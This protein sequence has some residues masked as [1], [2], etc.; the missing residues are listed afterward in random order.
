MS[1]RRRQKARRQP[2]AWWTAPWLAGLFLVVLAVYLG[3][4]LSAPC[5]PW[6]DW[7]DGG[8]FVS[9]LA[10]TNPGGPVGAVLSWSLNVLFGAVWVWTVPVL[11]LVI[12][13]ATLLQR[14]SFLGPL[15]LR[16]GPIWLV[17]TAWLGQP[18][19]PW[20][21]AES[22]RLAG[23]A[24]SWLG[25]AMHGLVGPW[26]SQLFLGLAVAVVLILVARPVLRPAFGWL[27]PV[28]RGL[29][30]ALAA[31]AGWGA[32]QLAAIWGRLRAVRL[33]QRR[34]RPRPADRASAVRVDA[35]G[36]ADLP[37]PAA[38]EPTPAQRARAIHWPEEPANGEAAPADPLPDVE[39]VDQLAATPAPAYHGPVE[40]P[41]LDLLTA[42]P[43]ETPE[44]STDELDAAAD[45]LE[46]TL[47]SFGV[48]G[49][50]KE[51]G[52][53]HV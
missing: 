19:W 20:G 45:L 53:A 26:G 39:D 5:A 33:P 21:D 25:R 49:E 38:A 12:G 18:G 14:T 29:L 48:E 52:R 34:E 24:G 50:V 2:E 51:I 31:V 27:A 6:W 22:T 35:E 16:L 43:Q 10:Y 36:P 42:M 7:L 1:G 15:F 3:L 4:S 32:D 13:L 47:R 37:E 44:L 46:Q 11:L 28:G 23:V 40:L 17:T 8:P 30:S 41:A 9:P